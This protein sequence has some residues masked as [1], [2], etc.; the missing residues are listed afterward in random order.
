M[1]LLQLNTFNNYLP[2]AREI[3]LNEFKDA[4]QEYVKKTRKSLI[5]VIQL[6][7]DRENLAFISFLRFKYK[8]ILS[9]GA[10][11]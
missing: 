5:E 8:H 1:Q 4:V 2:Q 9:Q 7:L 11:Q 10:T 3:A 6:L